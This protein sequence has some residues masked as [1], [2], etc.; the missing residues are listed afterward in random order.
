MNENQITYLGVISKLED[1]FPST[2]TLDYTKITPEEIWEK[3]E[4]FLKEI[5]V[6]SKMS[7]E[8]IKNLEFQIKS[9]QNMLYGKTTSVTIN[10]FSEKD[11]GFDQNNYRIKEIVLNMKSIVMDMVMEKGRYTHDRAVIGYN[12]YT[13]GTGTIEEIEETINHDSIKKYIKSLLTISKEDNDLYRI[14]LFQIAN[15]IL[16]HYALEEMEY[17]QQEVKQYIANLIRNAIDKS[18]TFRGEYHS[19]GYEGV[20]HNPEVFNSE[21]SK[22]IEELVMC[23][24][25]ITK[26][27]LEIGR[28]RIEENTNKPKEKSEEKPKQEGNSLLES[29]TKKFLKEEKRKTTKAD[30]PEEEPVQE[31]MPTIEVDNLSDLDSLTTTPEEIDYSEVLEKYEQLQE[32]IERNKQI[33][34]RIKELE[35]ERKKLELE[36]KTNEEL[37][38][39]GDTHG[40]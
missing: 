19:Y 8:E 30:I 18:A 38:K 28:K 10:S 37:I 14:E 5:K 11:H 9:N 17:S 23:I 22:I 21:V 20:D 24:E 39:S 13:E 36:L 27:A 31:E 25:D 2:T 12:G 40:I 15:E 26:K 1:I 6:L 34:K 4:D 29:L 7:L 3:V 32:L 35:L 16:R 33:I